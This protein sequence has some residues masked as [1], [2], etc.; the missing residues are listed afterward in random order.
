MRNGVNGGLRNKTK[1]KDE[2]DCN[3]TSFPKFPNKIWNTCISLNGEINHILYVTPINVVIKSVDTYQTPTFIVRVMSKGVQGN[4][5]LNCSIAIYNNY[6]SCIL[7]YCSEWYVIL[8]QKNS[9]LYNNFV[10]YKLNG[11]KNVINT[12]G[13]VIFNQ[14]MISIVNNNEIRI[15]PNGFREI[16]DEPTKELLELF[17]LQKMVAHDVKEIAALETANLAIANYSFLDT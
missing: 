9:L 15:N 11:V 5:T 16:T 10:Y 12:E 6:V 4:R 3:I 14:K 8:I 1:C 2:I 17:I 7:R 13:E